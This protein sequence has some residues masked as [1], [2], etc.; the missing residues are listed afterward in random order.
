MLKK[1]SD[2]CEK[3][4]YTNN[5]SVLICNIFFMKLKSKNVL[6]KKYDNKSLFVIDDLKSNYEHFITCLAS[7]ETN[8]IPILKLFCFAFVKL[9]L[10]YYILVGKPENPICVKIG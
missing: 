1:M 5:L 7:L 6:I 9:Y 8:E 4:K 2:D 3:S 10:Y